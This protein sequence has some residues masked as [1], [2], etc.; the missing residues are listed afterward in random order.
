[1]LLLAKIL[2]KFPFTTNV[3]GR[4]TRYINT[5]GDLFY[6]TKSRANIKF[7]Q[8]DIDLSN[9]EHDFFK[10]LAYSTQ[11]FFNTFKYSELGQFMNETLQKKD[12]FVDIGANVGG[13]SFLAKTL[14]ANVF[15][16][17]P[18][19]ALNNV[20]SDN[21]NVFG[22]VY[23]KAISNKNE[24]TEF[25]TS[26]INVEGSSLVM[27]NKGWEESGYTTKYEVEC[28]TFDEEFKRFIDKN[29]KI[30]LVKVDVEGNEYAAV[31]GMKL[32]LDKQIIENIWC[33]V[34]GH[35]SD[36]NPGSYFSVSELLDKNGY[37][38]FLIKDGVK[39][40]FD[41]KNVNETPQ[42]FDVLYTIE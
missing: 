23:S 39:E 42:Y 10:I 1:M 18:V 25:Y 38:A 6:S 22:N 9:D 16:Y 40:L 11:N 13:Y 37:K 33:E 34:R 19:I 24:V 26:D 32:A 4:K 2:S 20:L 29:T 21:P 12:V 30:K 28:V 27:S 41:W 14:Q 35:Q 8:F 5:F 3:S 17:E 7:N 15:A 31:E 36:R